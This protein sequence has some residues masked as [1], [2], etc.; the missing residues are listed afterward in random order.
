MR[1]VESLSQLSPS[2]IASSPKNVIRDLWDRLRGVS[3]GRLIF[4]R[5]VGV[6]APY[7]GTIGASVERLERGRAEVVMRD[8]KSVRNHLSSVHAVA[9]ANLAELTGN[10]ALSYALPD[11]ARFIVTGMSIEYLKKARGTIRGIS[12]C[13]LPDSSARQEYQV[14]VSLRN[15]SGEEVARATLRSL[16][17]PKREPA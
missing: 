16:V 10:I 14:P 2:A 1:F 7:T 9:L 15:E 5:L 13:P 4:S 12:E 11:D 3:G 6:A 8:R 17:G